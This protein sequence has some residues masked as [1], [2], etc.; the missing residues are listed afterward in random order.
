M[1]K[2]SAP[3]GKDSATLSP[4]GNLAYYYVARSGV[5]GTIKCAAG[6]IPRCTDAITVYISQ[7]YLVLGAC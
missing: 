5:H 4:T 2:D 6:L 7:I 3:M 1:V